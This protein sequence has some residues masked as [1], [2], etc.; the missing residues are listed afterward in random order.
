[1]TLAV[2]LINDF[3]KFEQNVERFTKRIMPKVQSIALEKTMADAAN[4]IAKSGERAL[5]NP[6]KAVFNGKK[7]RHSRGWIH[8]DWDERADI[9]RQKGQANG[10]VQLRGQGSNQSRAEQQEALRRQIYGSSVNDGVT[11]KVPYIIRPSKRLSREK[12]IKGVPFVKIDAHGNLRNYRGMMSKVA[13]DPR[14]F[15]VPLG[16]VGGGRNSNGLKLSPGLYFRKTRV[17]RYKRHKITKRRGA[18]YGS[19]KT[20]RTVNIITLLRYQRIRDYNR[21]W[22]FKDGVRKQMQAKYKDLFLI[23]L[24]RA[25]SKERFN[26][27]TNRSQRPSALF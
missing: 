14:F 11:P 10:F 13:N 2:S 9:K 3:D 23:E 7:S 16:S 27:R 6:I 17:R 22:D 19:S 20:K 26:A 5:D 25:I 1:M 24:T 4:N 18:P 21:A 15:H 8:W 12:K